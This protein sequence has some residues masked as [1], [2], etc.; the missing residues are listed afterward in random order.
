MSDILTIA[1]AADILKVSVKTVTRLC[2]RGELRYLL[3]GKQYRFRRAWLDAFIDS[4][5]VS[6]GAESV[7]DTP[8]KTAKIGPLRGGRPR[9]SG[10]A[11]AAR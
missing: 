5:V 6:N 3:V 11:P 7:A 9:A 4:N 2:L 1:E 8:V 10:A